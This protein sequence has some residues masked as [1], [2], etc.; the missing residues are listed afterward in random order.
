MSIQEKIKQDLK[1][2]MQEKAEFK[3]SVLRMLVSAIRN[4]EISER[5]GGEAELS[6]DQVIA[7]I[8]SEVKKRKDSAQTYKQGGRDDL[9]EKEEKE[10]EILEV[11]LP[12]QMSEEEIE[13]TIKETL[14]SSEFGPS[15]FGKAMGAVMPKLKGQADGGVVSAIL[16][17]VLNG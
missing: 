15:D 17:K 6:D 9:A 3:L 16:K 2:A 14:A 11:Y 10:I 7:V 13:K 1:S 8:K 4:K 5:K 12:E